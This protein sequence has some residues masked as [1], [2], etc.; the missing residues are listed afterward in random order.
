MIRCGYS[1]SLGMKLPAELLK[2]LACFL[3]EYSGFWP[4]KLPPKFNLATEFMFLA[5]ENSLLLILDAFLV[6]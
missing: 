1:F 2:I 5:F 6:L 4:E 3:D